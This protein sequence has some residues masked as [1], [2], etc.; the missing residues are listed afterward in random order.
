LRGEDLRGL[1]ERAAPLPIPREVN[2]VRDA[3]MGIAAVHRAGLVHRDLKPGNLFV[4]RRASGEDWCKVL[5][6][7]V[8]KMDASSSTAE[9][10]LIGTAKYMAP[11]QLKDGASAGP[12]ADI[13]ALG[14]ILYEC[15]CGTPPH[16]GMSA[17]E[18]MFKIMNEA[19]EWLSVRRAENP[20]RTFHCCAPRA[21][22]APW[23]TAWHSRGICKCDCTVRGPGC[24]A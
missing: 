3:C 2:L 8:A 9:G 19:P 17:Q 23:R 4:T 22:E 10:A 6:F 16:T 7:G 15:L 11:E 12:A 21:V 18:L 13:Y 5:D 24:Q 1:L 14:A 20:D